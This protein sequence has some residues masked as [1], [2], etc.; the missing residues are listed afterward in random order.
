MYSWHD[1]PDHQTVPNWSLIQDQRTQPKKFKIKLVRNS[2]WCPAIRQTDREVNFTVES[3]G[4][5][6]LFKQ[7]EYRII[8]ES[9]VMIRVS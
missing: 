4:I 6:E 9:V 2:K 5:N 3:A 7:L 8:E 1:R